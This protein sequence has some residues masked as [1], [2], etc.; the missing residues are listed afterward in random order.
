MI[1]AFRWEEEAAA[2][3]AHRL[4]LEYAGWGRWKDRTKKI[5]AK[6][7]DGKLVRIDPRVAQQEPG[8]DHDES[9]AHIDPHPED[10]DV[11][12]QYGVG[13]IEG[14]GF[15]DLQYDKKMS[16]GD[17]IRRVP[18][19]RDTGLWQNS[20]YIPGRGYY[21]LVNGESLHSY[22]QKLKNAAV[23]MPV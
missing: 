16:L 21:R 5:V 13:Y 22:N 7:V 15:I 6:T 3:E 23:N 9:L 11:L 8:N 10:L 18:E 12:H 2:E 17:V 20:N 19:F 14:Q 4:G 1:E